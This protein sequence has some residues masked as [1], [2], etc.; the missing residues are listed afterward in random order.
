MWDINIFI[1]QDGAHQGVASVVGDFVRGLAGARPG[2][3]ED[4]ACCIS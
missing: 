2:K 4:S 1:S 3:I